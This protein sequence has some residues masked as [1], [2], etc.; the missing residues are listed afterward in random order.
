M[1]HVLFVDKKIPKED[2]AKWK[3]EDKAFWLKYCDVN[4]IYWDI[5]TDFSFYP[6][7]F[8]SDGDVKP[9]TEYLKEK[10]EEVYKTYNSDGTDF[11]M[12]LIHQ[13]NWRGSGALF[14]K[15]RKEAGLPKQKGVWGTNWSN[16]YRN[17]HVQFCRWDKLNQANNFGTN[18][19][20]RH[21]ALDSLVATEIGYN[22]NNNFSVPWDSIT[23]GVDPWDYI[24]YK[25]NTESISIIAPYLKLALAKRLKRHEDYVRGQQ[26]TIIGLLE[27]IVYLYRQQLYKKDGVKKI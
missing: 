20:E 25:E 8:D 2:L 17:Y 10:T 14:D 7:N 24:R 21:H 22:V 5:E 19:H 18:Y 3:K 13:D 12:F 15:L 16:K 26:L 27:K 9:T 11:I 23:H 1:R 6:T 4:A